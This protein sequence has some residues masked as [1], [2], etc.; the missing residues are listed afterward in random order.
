MS[1]GLK[2]NLNKLIG[3]WK[4]EGV[5]VDGGEHDGVKIVGTDRYEW[6]GDA[7]IVHY[8][9]VMF[10]DTPQKTVEIFQLEEDGFAM[11]AYNSTGSVETMHGTFDADGAYK[12]GDEK[13]RTTLTFSASGQEMQAI[14]EMRAGGEWTRWI[15]MSFTRL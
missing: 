11:T 13:V 2:N 1:T 9:D 10:G 7:F 14:W 12:A 3:E 5:V 8:A 15:E 6:L 4:S